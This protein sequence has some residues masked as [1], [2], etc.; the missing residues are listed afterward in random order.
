MQVVKQI[1]VT[2]PDGFA[3]FQVS[4]GSTFEV[5]PN[6]RSG[7]P[8]QSVQ[9][10]RP[11]WIC[12]RASESSHR[13]ARGQPNNNRVNTPT[14]VISVRGTAFDVAVEEGIPRSWLRKRGWSSTCAAPV[15]RAEAAEFR[16]IPARLSRSASGSE[17]FSVR[18]ATI[19]QGLR[20]AAEA[21]YRIVYRAPTAGG[22]PVP[23]STGG[24]RPGDT[25]TNNPPPP[26]PPPPP[27]A[28]ANE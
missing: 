7:I 23:G 9:P 3:I 27:A 24:G 19:Q 1:I 15:E 18:D 5:F 2:G 11:A 26:P 25:D 28:P 10:E 6:S 16:R 13:K 21:I 8:R 22:S 14:A 20:A 12:A 17:F 4:D